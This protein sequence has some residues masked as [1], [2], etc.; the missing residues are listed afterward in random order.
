[1]SMG[2]GKEKK[3]K[4]KTKDQKE[5]KPSSPKEA[6][7]SSPPLQSEVFDSSSAN[8][9]SEMKEVADMGPDETTK[10][11][12]DVEGNQQLDPLTTSI[13]DSIKA[14]DS[15]SSTTS[16]MAEPTLQESDPGSIE[17]KVDNVVPKQ[18]VK[19]EVPEVH[20]ESAGRDYLDE[21]VAVYDS[22]NKVFYSNSPNNDIYNPFII[23]IKFWQ[24]YSIACIRAYN[25]FLK[26]WSDNIR[27][28]NS[29][30]I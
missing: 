11:F 29:N 13:N 8:A 15:G 26:A 2:L 16:P 7:T 1:M 20:N 28:T 14:P 17:S 3:S 10:I 18:D 25:G 21:S 22:E 24:A 6:V 4:D 27:L 12:L 30:T 19:S 9:M 23:G 5:E